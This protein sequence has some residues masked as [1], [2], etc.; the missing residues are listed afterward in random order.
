MLQMSKCA[1]VVIIIGT[2]LSAC[3]SVS[4]TQPEA[5]EPTSIAQFDRWMV[6]YSN[7]GRWGENDELGA[8]NL[9]TDEKRLEAAAL[10]QTGRTVSLS[11]DFLTEEADDARAVSVADD[12]EH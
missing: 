2:S 3:E 5:R 11:H 4:F 9:M 8:A 10:I 7:W 6:E 1:S 12:G